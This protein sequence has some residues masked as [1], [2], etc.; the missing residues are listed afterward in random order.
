M[1]SGEE[2]RGGHGSAASGGGGEGEGGE[3]ASLYSW[4]SKAVTVKVLR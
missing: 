1:E 4:D 3:E 2:G